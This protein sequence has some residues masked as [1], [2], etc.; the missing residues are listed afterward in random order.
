M[1][2]QCNNIKKLAQTAL[3]TDDLSQPKPNLLIIGYVWP[4]PN[5]SAAGSRMMQLIEV[6]QQQGF[7]VHFASPAETSPHTPDL[8]A[9]N[10]QLHNIALNC[11]SFDQFVS[12]LDPKLVMFDRFMMEE[13][14]GWRVEQQCPDALRV[15]DTEDLHFLRKARHQ[16][17]KLQR[18]YSEAELSNE[19]TIREVASIFRCDLTLIISEYEMELLQTR[20]NVPKQI[21]CYCPFMLSQKSIESAP[22]S[23]FEQRKHFISI[24]NFRH[25]PNWDS[26]LQLKT[27][28]WPRIRKLLP[29][30]HKDAELHIYGA[31]PAKKATQLN[32]PKE[33]FL[34]KGWA[35]N[36]LEVVSQARV[37]L[38]PLRFGAGLKGK[39][40]DAA[41]CE[42]PAVTSS[43]GSEAMY[44]S[45]IPAVTEDQPEQFAKQAV[46]L[47]CQH[48][49]WQTL[50]NACLPMLN[51]RFAFDQ[52]S[53]QLISQL[54]AI[55]ESLTQHRALNF[56]GLM[57]RYHS[58]KSTQYMSQW[59][60]AK[61]RLKS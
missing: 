46:A 35:E 1:P 22:T 60:E 44:L 61:N 50:S 56:T 20:F 2:D 3:N 54:G 28:I 16:A 37:L 34:V 33:R 5:S 19:Q 30:E 25:E 39:L 45:N 29:A 14:F 48:K 58:M 12:D 42:T 6:F 17:I 18:P 55:F 10:I 4:E 21:L 26:V 27:E 13:Q 57:L 11:S 15:L 31:Y 7:I 32:N 36:A 59:I 40:I 52:H 51:E 41:L 38:A 8:T 24:G 23:P 43:I 9:L 47:Y 49:Q 53:A